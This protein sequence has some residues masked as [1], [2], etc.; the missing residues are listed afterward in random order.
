MKYPASHGMLLFWQNLPSDVGG[1]ISNEFDGRLFLTVAP[2]A[3]LI[4]TGG[5]GP[6]GMQTRNLR[7]PVVEISPAALIGTT[8]YQ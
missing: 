4:S 1:V 3:G 8:V 7:T 5:V 6:I 2:V